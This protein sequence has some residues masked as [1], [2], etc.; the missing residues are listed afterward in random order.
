MS[1]LWFCVVEQELFNIWSVLHERCRP[2]TKK[3][4]TVQLTTRVQ[5]RRL[6]HM[7][8]C[9]YSIPSFIVQAQKVCTVLFEGNFI[10]I[11]WA[12]LFCRAT[13]KQVV[14]DPG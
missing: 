7:G 12:L 8:Q 3:S 4:T 13:I 2:Q 5:R 11:L 1:E 6:A 9:S 14:G 10:I